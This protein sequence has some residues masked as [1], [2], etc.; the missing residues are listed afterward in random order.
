MSAAESPVA[1]PISIRRVLQH[2]D[3]SAIA[4]LHRRVYEREYGLNDRFTE[5]VERDVGAAVSS[6]WPRRAGAVWLV[7]G[8]GSLLG[9]LALTAEGQRVG[10]VRWFA[11][12][13]SVRGRGLGR[14]L[15]DELLE[16]AR[17]GGLRTLRLE[18]IKLLTVAAHIYT[19]NG[20]RVIWERERTDWGPP[21]TYQG[22]E[23]TLG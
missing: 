12:D 11:L 22:Y 16:E 18:T 6:G 10:R 21:V 5:T 15:I 14:A 9:A 19:S 23:L 13:R 1:G 17:S 8:G 3:G 2:G 20:F 7:H 4:D